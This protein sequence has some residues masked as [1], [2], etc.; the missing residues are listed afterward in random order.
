MY[1]VGRTMQPLQSETA[2]GDCPSWRRECL[3][4]LGE[5]L[6]VL[7]VIDGVQRVCVVPSENRISGKGDF[8][9]DVVPAR[10]ILFVIQ[11][12]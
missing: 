3:R 2:R 12:V 4:R 6:G 8:T 7:E 1:Q 5:L 9:Q 11:A 10:A